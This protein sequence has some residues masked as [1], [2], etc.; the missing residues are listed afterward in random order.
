MEMRY[1]TS[2]SVSKHQ[3]LIQ[4]NLQLFQSDEVSTYIPCTDATDSAI[5]VVL[6]QHDEEHRV[7]SYTNRIL[8]RAEKNYFTSDKDI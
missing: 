1:P 2:A 7:I 8:K 6:Y 5:G 4:N 3:G